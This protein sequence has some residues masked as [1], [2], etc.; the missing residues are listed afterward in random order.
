MTNTVNLNDFRRMWDVISEDVIAAV[1]RVGESGWFVL[2]NEVEL[3]EQALAARF[4]CNHAI[5]VGNGLD[6]VEIALRS[7]GIRPSDHVVTTPLSAFATTLAILHIGAVP[8]FCDVDECGILDL[9]HCRELLKE[10]PRPKAVVIVHLY[11]HVADLK[12]LACLSDDY[13]VVII[14]D[15]AQCIGATYDGI[16]CGS[17]GAA[18]A[19]S[20]YPTKN[21]GTLGDGGA[22][23]TDNPRIAEAA[24]VLRDYGQSG[25]YVHSRLGLNSRLDEVH[26]AVLRTAMLP[27]LDEWTTRRRNIAGRYCSAIVNPGVHTLNWD[28]AANPV[29]HLFPVVLP[30]GERESFINHL[31]DLGVQ[32]GIHYPTLIPEQHGMIEAPQFMVSDEMRRARA[33]SS[34]EVSLPIHPFLTDDEV[35]RV[36]VGCNS[37]K[38]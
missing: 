27:H 35:T 1:R 19:I 4:G 20:F 6:A 13:D 33:I 15:C 3:F 7:A 32:T 9:D 28:S 11:G 12:Q 36:I 8:V 31:R 38:T 24:R 14:E 18:S 34:T 2:G 21:L 5:G 25:K 30:A 26:A 22:V 16:Q 17:I 23:L 37:W 29:W 10:D